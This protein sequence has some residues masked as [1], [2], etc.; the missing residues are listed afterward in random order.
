MSNVNRKRRV[1][2]DWWHHPIPKNV[3]YGVG[4]YCET[5]QS[6]RHFKSKKKRAVVI[7]DHVSC[8]AGCS[9]AIGVK[10]SCSIGD[11]TLVNGAL[12]M[13]EE[14]IEIGAHCLISWNVGLADSD[15]HPLDVSQRY[16]DTLALAPYFKDRKPITD[17]WG[18]IY[19]Y[20]YSNMMAPTL[21]FKTPN[22][23]MFTNQDQ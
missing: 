11:F 10:G 23:T 4:F 8:Y 20:D 21:G 19:L 2:G 15:F 17:P 13:A 18:N 9:F 6:F 1:E 3:H 7:G 12:I 5:A 16:V 14:R 22:G